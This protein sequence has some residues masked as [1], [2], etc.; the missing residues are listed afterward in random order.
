MKGVIV[1]F[2]V[3]DFLDR[4]ETVYG[5]RIGLHDEPDQPAPSWG[6]LTYAEMARRAR[7]IAARLDELGVAEGERVAM[8]SHNS[9]RLLTAFWGV[10]GFGRVLVPVNFRLSRDEVAYI[11][12]HSG[13]KALFVDPE[14]ED[15]LKGVEGSSHTFVMGTDEDLMV[16]GDDADPRPWEK[17]D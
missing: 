8:V 12:Q 4:A 9:G 2:T 7:R 15:A 11:V 5:D 3:S 13:A 16:D 6:D 14:L 10:S 1:P 17:P